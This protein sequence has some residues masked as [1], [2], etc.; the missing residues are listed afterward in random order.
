MR[1]TYKPFI[2]L[3]R[4]RKDKTFCVFIRVGYQSKYSYIETEYSASKNDIKGS[5][6]KSGMLNDKC[7]TIIAE[8]RA[9]TDD[10]SE[11]DYDDVNQVVEFIKHKQEHRNG[12]DYMVYLKNHIDKL[13]KNNSSSIQ[14]YNA[15]YNHFNTF[16]GRNTLSTNGLTSKLLK[17]FEEYLVKKEVGSHGIHSYL[18]KIRAVYNLM[19]DDYEE[20]GYTFKYPFR[21]YKIPEPI[22]KPTI[23]LTKE[24]LIE[25][26]DIELEEGSRAS[27]IRNTFMISLL[28]LGTNATDLYDLDTIKKGRLEY[29]RNKTKNKRISDRA[30]ISIK[31]EPELQHY[32]DLMKGKNEYVF[33][34]RERFTTKVNLNDSIRKGVKEI[35]DAIN[36]KYI[37]INK[38][39]Y[40]QNKFIQ[41]F[42]YYDARRTL[43]SVMRNTL[44]ISKDNVA[45]CLNHKDREH[46]TTDYY[47]EKDFSILDKC[48]RQFLDW[49]YD[50]SI[51]NNI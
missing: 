38:T 2:R 29:C 47:I 37:T 40:T 31:I 36:T 45:A 41:Y 1:V 7:N 26:R 12:V 17:E 32:I 46:K 25:I 42:D 19:I 44:D 10:L 4:Q 21:K 50:K 20:L 33:N 34:F 23:A 11:S 51:I 27:Y 8:Y 15:T 18:S 30:F 24:Q 28:S 16:V 3:Q 22:N 9:I 48:N 13:E 6:I 43:A 49:L 39:K 5:G 35:A 14:I